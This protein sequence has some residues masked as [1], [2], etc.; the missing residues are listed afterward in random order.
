MQ[1]EQQDRATSTYDE[2][3]DLSFTEGLSHNSETVVCRQV[4]DSSISIRE[5]SAVDSFFI[6][7][8]YSGKNL[9]SFSIIK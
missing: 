2:D 8:G 5:E 9:R 4:G 7:S 1:I 6:I 3:K